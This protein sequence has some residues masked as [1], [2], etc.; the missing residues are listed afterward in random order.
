MKRTR[1]QIRL[2]TTLALFALVIAFSVNAK[3]A[4]Y[5]VTNTADSGADTLRAA[6][7]QANAS[8]A[9]DTINFSIP[10]T[11]AGCDANGICTITLTSGE[12]AI[13]IASTAGKLTIT[14][15]T[16]ASNLLI[17]GNNASRVFF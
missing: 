8:T 11:G 3:A 1:K 9:N 13:E 15:S 5:T 14:N 12:L 10:A 4:T 17:S 16:G 2:F 7:T 6:V